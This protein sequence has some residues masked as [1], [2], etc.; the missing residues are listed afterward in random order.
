MK[1]VVKFFDFMVEWGEEIY[2][3]RK[4]HNYKIGYY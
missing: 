1:L 4:K 3:Y 2:K